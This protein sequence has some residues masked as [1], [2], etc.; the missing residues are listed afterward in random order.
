VK[1]DSIALLKRVVM[2]S[3]LLTILPEEAVGEE[4]AKGAL[5][6]LRCET[7]AEYAR[8]GFMFRTESL[9]TPQMQ[10]LTDRIRATITGST[11]VT[12]IAGGRIAAARQRPA[13]M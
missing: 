1:T 12:N 5:T 7:P 10:L 4:I 9:T 13:A 2:A 11:A 3:D 8:V 6:T